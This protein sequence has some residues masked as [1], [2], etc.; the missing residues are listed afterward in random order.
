MLLHVLCS[1]S[2]SAM[3]C[4]WSDDDYDDDDFLGITTCKIIGQ[5]VLGEDG[6]QA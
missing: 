5:A 2:G 1:A 6:Y 3:V 4:S